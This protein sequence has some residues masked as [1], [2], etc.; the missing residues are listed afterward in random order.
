MNLHELNP[1]IRKGQ[2]LWMEPASRSQYLQNL[3]NKIAAGYYYSDKVISQ[4]VDELAPVI[5]DITFNK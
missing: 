2:F 1:A 4:V 3:K 5:D